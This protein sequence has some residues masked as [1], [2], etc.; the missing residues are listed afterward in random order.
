VD[1]RQSDHFR[2]VFLTL[3]KMGFAQADRC[4]HVPYEMVELP[5]GPMSGRTG[6]VVLFRRLRQQ[7][8]EHLRREYFAKFEGE[9]PPEE[10][11][12]AEQA[13]ALGAIKYGMLNRD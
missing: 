2:H 3:K 8:T 9:W 1:V 10:I 7:M 6:N 12:E 5:E 11:A 4:Q 13:V